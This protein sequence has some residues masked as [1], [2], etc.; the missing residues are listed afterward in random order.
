MGSPAPNYDQV[1]GQWTQ[2]GY[3]SCPNENSGETSWVGLGGDLGPPLLQTGTLTFNPSNTSVNEFAEWIGKNG[4]N[5]MVEGPT[6]TPGDY[7]ESYVSWLPGAPG[8]NGEFDYS[9]YDVMSGKSTAADIYISENYHDP[10]LAPDHATAEAVDE[11]PAWTSGG[12]TQ[13]EA[14]RPFNNGSIFWSAIEDSQYPSYTD[15]VYGNQVS[16]D[17]FTMSDS[18]GTLATPTGYNGENLTDTW[19]QCGHWDPA[20]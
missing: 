17:N 2:T 18:L 14:L 4:T 1:Y 11:R 13:Y 19:K 7:M 10:Y 6:V 8:G 3:G 5:S 16:Y 20:G 15:G 12:T 9:T